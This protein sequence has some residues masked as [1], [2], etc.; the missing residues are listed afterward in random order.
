M[1]GSAVSKALVTGWLR[2]GRAAVRV[3]PFY[4]AAAEHHTSAPGRVGARAAQLHVQSASGPI[5]LAGC[6]DSYEP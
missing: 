6:R 4:H 3:E 5:P 2:V 1:A